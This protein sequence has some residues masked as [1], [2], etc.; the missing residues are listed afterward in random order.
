MLILLS[1]GEE[2]WKI[3]SPSDNVKFKRRGN[4]ER[5]TEGGEAKTSSKCWLVINLLEDQ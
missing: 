3:Y 4:E 2:R 1:K 5:R